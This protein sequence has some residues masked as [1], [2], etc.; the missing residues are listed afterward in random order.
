MVESVSAS[1]N[2]LRGDTPRG[3]RNL[4]LLHGLGVHDLGRA[5]DD[6][7]ADLAYGADAAGCDALP[8]DAAWLPSYSGPLEAALDPTSIE[9]V[10]PQG[11]A[12]AQEELIRALDLSEEVSS[13][14]LGIREQIADRIRAGL[15]WIADH[16][17]LDEVVIA[18]AF[19]EVAVYLQ[20]PDAREAALR[21]VV[22][23]LP[24][25]GDIVL[26]AHS[27]GSIVAIDLLNSRSIPQVTDVVTCGSPL[28]IDAVLRTIPGG[29]IS[30]VGV[31]WTNV[32]S[33]DD[34]VTIGTPLVDDWGEGVVDREIRGHRDDAHAF[35]TYL[36]TP[37]VAEIVLKALAFCGP[38]TDDRQGAPHSGFGPPPRQTS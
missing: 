35:G 22:A 34:P 17:P 10:G 4:V 15:T 2:G 38:R 6:W 8:T 9:T 3:S 32:W 28:G 31:R 25:D 29:S 13:A 33:A 27:L 30:P 20:N 18:L 7:M 19:R 12:E 37:A 26:V 1:M 16:S 23:G 24:S 36:A 21:E 14:S 5:R 11:I